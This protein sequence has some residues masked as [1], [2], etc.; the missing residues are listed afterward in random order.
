MRF[1][2][3]QE[4]TMISTVKQLGSVYLLDN[5]IYAKA[6]NRDDVVMVNNLLAEYPSKE[7]A[8]QATAD[9]YKQYQIFCN[10]NGFR[11]ETKINF[12]KEVNKVLGT[13]TV[14]SHIGKGKER[15]TIRIFAE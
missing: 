8:K 15:K 11:Q 4:M 7:I 5:K 1:V 13:K 3:N 12:S 2:V 14:D 6:F 9:V 10:D